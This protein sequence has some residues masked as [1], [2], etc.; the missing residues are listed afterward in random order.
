MQFHHIGHATKSI[1]SSS[2]AI[3][4]L[5]YSKES[6][7]IIDEF[8]DVRIEFWNSDSAPR[9]ELIEPIST[10]SPVWKILFKRGGPYH[11]AYEVE[12]ISDIAKAFKA[13]K[14]RPI[15]ELLPA[16]AFNGR[17]VQFFAG[18]DGTAYELIAMTNT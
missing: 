5:G 11:Y 6:E 9:I 16:V 18:A 3:S 13:R 15:S 4:D 1:R 10:E 8:L 12:D 14:I 7:L 2:E 17:N